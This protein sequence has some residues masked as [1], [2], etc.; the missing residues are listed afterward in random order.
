MTQTQNQKL[1]KSPSQL[2]AQNA[3][4]DPVMTSLDEELLSVLARR[5]VASRK[6]NLEVLET[7]GGK[8]NQAQEQLLLTR[9]IEKGRELGL[10]THFVLELYNTI[11]EDGVH[12]TA[13][14]VQTR[15]NPDIAHE[16]NR[17]AL[18]GEEGSYSHQATH[19]FFDPRPGQ[20]AEVNCTSF[21]QVIEKV[22]SGRADFGVLP[23]ENSTAGGI[24]DVYDILQYTNL[25]IVGEINHTI[26][27]CLLTRD[28]AVKIEDIKTL[29]A[30]PQVHAQCSHFLSQLSNI[31]VEFCS[32]TS[33]AMKK[34][35]DAKSA[36]CAA[37]GGDVGS[38]V[39][40]LKAI[41]SDL[42]NQKENYTRFI[43]VAP[44]PV[45]VAQTI[46]SKTSVIFSVEQKPGSLVDVLTVLKNNELKMLKLESRPIPGNP[47]EEMFYID[48]EGNI[49]NDNVSEAIDDM[50]LHTRFMKVLGCF[51]RGDIEGVDINPTLL[52]PKGVKK[53]SESKEADTGA[54]KTG[55]KSKSTKSYK[56]VSREHQQEDTIIRVKGVTI[57]GDSF[58]TMAGPCS[59]ESE[60]QI[61][62]CA[63]Q[64]KENSG[65]ILRGG[66]FKPRT[67]PYS[68]QGMGYEGLDIMEKAGKKYGLPIITEVMSEEDVVPIAKQADFL[69]IGARN[70]QNFPLLKAV[71]KVHR[72]VFLKRGMMSSI[73]ELL[74][75][76]EYI[77]AHGNKQV[78]LCERGIRTFE[79][80]TR[81]TLDLSAVPI[82][83]ELTHLPIMIDPSH[84]VGRRDLVAPM[85]KASKAVGS[86][87]IMVE[88]HPNP[89]VAKSD[90]PQA[91]RFPQFA[92]LMSEL[93]D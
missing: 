6:Q 25:S 2:Q 58:V 68:F 53:D 38:S 75:A 88:I 28:P 36:N 8:R 14:E 24:N 41:R 46:P 7:S 20:V 91:L 86:H 22:E 13:L 17:I 61:M 73:D 62:D 77:L 63:R 81:N 66:C 90:G 85:S 76:A 52:K 16:I 43:V 9:C 15:E 3:T 67:N 72:P 50:G 31:N 19:R 32:S 69:Q 65:T 23:L 93:Y 5:K 51:P 78:I 34:V 74:N 57:G 89:E 10:D 54:V 42:A 82:L 80:A 29:Y 70:M 92:E 71:G 21:K 56:L 39:Y 30:H 11:I 27:H 79:T 45:K 33:S 48:I 12:A 55:K 4:L 59:V 40:G 84:A 44:K 18:L 87:G 47:W 60:E 64:V 1:N 49:D 35:R 83:K 26:G 37:I